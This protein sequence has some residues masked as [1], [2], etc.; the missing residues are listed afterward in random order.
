MPSLTVHFCP[1]HTTPQ[2]LAGGVVVVI[3]ILRAST[4]IIAALAAGAK[5]VVPCL[6]V[7]D[8]MEA[9][10]RQQGP[11]VLGGERGGV[12]IAGFA[13]GNSPAEYTPASVGGKTVVFTTTNGTRA[14][15]QC[16]AASRVL[17][18]A[19]VNLS[20]VVRQLVSA[21]K[22]HLLC[23]GTDGHI[24]REDVLFAGA[25]ADALQQRANHVFQCNDEAQIAVEA[26]RGAFASQPAD[27]KSLAPLLCA[28]RGGIN[29]I[30]LGYKGDIDLAAQ[31]DKLAI[32]PRLDPVAWA[33]RA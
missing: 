21:T 20:A 29:L 5:E 3:D 26:W 12:K 16:L 30:E 9:A 10:A 32:V 11:V 17:I 15:M 31:I 25:V 4:T 13:L 24:T 2:E 22:I 7:S 6:E 33:I 27:A 19:F 23:A 8:A 28:S 18:G 1:A 14:L